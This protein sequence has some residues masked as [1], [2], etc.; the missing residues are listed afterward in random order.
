MILE[1]QRQAAQPINAEHRRTAGSTDSSG[2]AGGGAPYR[3]RRRV[4]DLGCSLR[5]AG[6]IGPDPDTAFL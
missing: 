5:S 1:D 4:G 6:A 2:A 3:A